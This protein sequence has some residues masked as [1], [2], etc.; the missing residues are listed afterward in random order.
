MKKNRILTFSESINEALDQA[1]QID[2]NVFIFGQGVDKTALVF[3]TT[4]G[5]KEKHGSK[6]IFDTPNAEMGETA[7]AAGAANAGLRPILIHHRVDFMAYTFDQLVNWISLWTFKS[8]KKNKGGM[9]IVIR[10]IIGKGWGQGPQHAKTLHSMFAYLP[11]LRVV[12]PSSPSEAK[13]L[14]LSSIFSNDPVIFLEYRSIYN[15][16]E[17]VPSKP[18]FIDFNSPRIRYKGNKVTIVAIGSGVLNSIK[19]I[20]AM[21]AEGKV[22]LIDLRE[23]SNFKYDIIIKS[24]KKTKKLIVVEDGWEK[25]SVASEIIS[26][27][28]EMGINLKKPPIKICWPSSHVPMSSPLEKSFYPDENN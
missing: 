13:G 23:I 1:M 25:F 7:L 16:R 8:S 21:K 9:P 3:K 22:E 20:E 12:I 15:T 24:L 11:G 2:K 19:A 27:V 5:L 17:Y 28:V 6:R 4:Q 26:R 10:G 14:L 18:Y